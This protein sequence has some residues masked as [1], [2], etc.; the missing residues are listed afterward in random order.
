LNQLLEQLRETQVYEVSI[1]PKSYQVEV[2][3]LENTDKYVHLSVSV[4][5][6]TLPWSTVPLTEGILRYKSATSSADAR[7]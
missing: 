2:E 1:G 6:G 7:A 3:I 5:D 4:D